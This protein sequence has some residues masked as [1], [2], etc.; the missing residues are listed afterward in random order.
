[1]LFA[2]RR[3]FPKLVP[4]MRRVVE[5]MP[6]HARRQIKRM[7][8]RLDAER[9]L[10]HSLVVLG[11]MAWY[12]ASRL[13]RDRRALLERGAP[14]IEALGLSAAQAREYAGLVCTGVYFER[15]G[16]QVYTML[17]RTRLDNLVEC[18][19]YL[20]TNG[21]EGSFL[22]A[23]VWKGGAGILMRHVARTLRADREVY[24]LDSFRG[25]ED[26]AGQPAAEAGDPRDPLCAQLLSIAEAYFG[27]PII[28][29][30]VAEVRQNVIDLLGSDD[31]VS[32]IEGWFSPEF[33]W[34]EVPPLALIRIDCDYYLPTWHCLEGLYD[35]LAPGGCIIFDEYYLDHMGEGRAADEFR[36]ARG[37]EDRIIRIDANS[38]YWIKG[39]GADGT[40][41]R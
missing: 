25:M 41:L 2:T 27:Q 21:I 37:I 5:T 10:N 13:K 18:C 7:T 12:R 28:E 19:G 36:A 16:A 34:H 35:K 14:Q 30:S 33:P 29:T 17:P 40:G 3:V 11:R 24:L 23:G 31:G 15:A 6:Q 20:I 38:G 32:C 4:A 39:S 1:M 26:I 22:E 8:R 9:L